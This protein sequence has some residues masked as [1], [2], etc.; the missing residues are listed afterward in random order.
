MKIHYKLLIY[1]LIKTLTKMILSLHK[2][3]RFKKN[4]QEILIIQR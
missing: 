1:R 4:W 2:F 3:I